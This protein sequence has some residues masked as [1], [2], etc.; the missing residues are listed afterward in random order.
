MSNQNF[1]DWSSI[2]KAMAAPF[3]EL[4]NMNSRVLEQLSKESMEIASSNV[5]SA[6]KHAQISMKTK[7]AEDFIKL[8]MDFMTNLGSKCLEHGKKMLG[9]MECAATD[10]RH[11]GENHAADALKKAGMPHQECCHSKKEH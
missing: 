9:M 7:E 4:H 6:I 8:Q 11:W 10:Y 1:S 3:A 5:A 2:S